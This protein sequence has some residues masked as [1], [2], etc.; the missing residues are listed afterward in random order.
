M[1][2]DAYDIGL[3]DGI[4]QGR[5]EKQA[6]DIKL[7]EELKQNWSEKVQ[8]EYGIVSAINADEA[9]AAIKGDN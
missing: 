5:A 6:E 3:A 1:G 9:I 7:L 4:A 2:I 8:F